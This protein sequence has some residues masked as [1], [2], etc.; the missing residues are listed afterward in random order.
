MVVG[1]AKED[2]R[3]CEWLKDKAKRSLSVFQA[4]KRGKGGRGTK[5]L[6]S[7]KYMLGKYKCVGV[8]RKLGGVQNACGR[9][10]VPEVLPWKMQNA[11]KATP[12]MPRQGGNKTSTT[13]NGA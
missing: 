3:Q 6:L 11:W 2:G 5:F 12:A 7:H 10:G 4:R 8:G 1:K 13:Q 9:Q